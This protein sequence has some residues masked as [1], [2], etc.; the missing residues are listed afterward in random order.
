[1]TLLRALA[2]LSLFTSGLQAGSIERIW[3]SH[4]SNQPNQ[5]VI[6]WE[7]QAPG[8]SVVEFGPTSALGQKVILEDKVTLH[9]VKIPLDFKEG[10][11]HYRVRSGDDVSRVA[12]FKNYSKDTLRVIIV[13]DWGYSKVTDF[14]AVLR[15]DP[16]LLLSAGDNV[17]SLHEKGREGTRAFSALIDQQPALFRSLPFLPIL[18]NHDREITP[19]GPKPPAHAVYDIEASA[20]REFFALPGDEWKWHFDLPDFDLRFIALDLNHIQDFGTTWQTCHPYDA[21]SAQ[22]LEYRDLMAQTKAGFVFTLMNEKQTA[23]QGLTKGL[24]HEEFVK[25]SA[26]VTGFGY[27]ADRAELKGGLPY[28]NTCLKGDGSPY[29]DPQSKF[30]AQQDNYLLLTFQR[31]EPTMQV[32]FKNM[33]GEVLDTTVIPKRKL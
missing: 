24:W 28:F 8:D 6:N 5:M 9:H 27:F 31:G 1:M 13:A 29:K 15:D 11:C 23:V 21:S 7:T 2:S 3:L 33:Q 14:S 18:G 10:L 19:R 17:A 20:Y 32:Q 30:F 26:L 25:G 16:H 4:P 12:T 22:F